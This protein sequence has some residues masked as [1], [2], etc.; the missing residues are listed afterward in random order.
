MK[1]VGETG[2]AGLPVR[3]MFP[4][5]FRVLRIV[6]IVALLIPMIISCPAVG[7]DDALV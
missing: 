3:L 1:D 2:L 5:D 7:M 4:E 6:V